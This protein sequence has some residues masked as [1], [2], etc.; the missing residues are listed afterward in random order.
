MNSMK[1]HKIIIIEG[2]EEFT[3]FIKCTDC[4]DFWFTTVDG[5]SKR[6]KEIKKQKNCDELMSKHAALRLKGVK[7]ERTLSEIQT[8]FT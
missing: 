3:K 6:L 7:I 1:K 5:L 8:W 4:G 2:K